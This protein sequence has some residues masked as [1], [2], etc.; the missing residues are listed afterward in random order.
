MVGGRYETEQQ[1]QQVIVLEPDNDLFD[2][3]IEKWWR[4]KSSTEVIE[5][6]EALS[7]YLQRRSDLCQASDTTRFEQTF[8]LISCA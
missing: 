2:F 6:L 7:A 8:A 1:G 4:S 5:V 3:I